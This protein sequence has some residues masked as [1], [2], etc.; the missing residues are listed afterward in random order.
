MIFLP[1]INECDPDPC[2]NG[3][4]CYDGLYQYTCV[5]DDRFTGVNCERRKYYS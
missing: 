3:G 2:D 4:T 1:D 5:C